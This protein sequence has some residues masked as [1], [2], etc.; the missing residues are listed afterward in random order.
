MKWLVVVVACASACKGEESP[1]ASGD[2]VAE[3]A[4]SHT[5]GLVGPLSSIRVT[6]E[7]V[8]H[9]LPK[10]MCEHEASVAAWCEY[11][12]DRYPGTIWR[13]ERY[14]WSD[15]KDELGWPITTLR[16]TVKGP[17]AD[18]KAKLDSAWGAPTIAGETS[19][20]FAP[21][22]HLRVGLHAARSHG[23]PPDLVDI[24][25]A[26]YL[27]LGEVMGKGGATFGFEGG[28]P[29]L[30]ATDADVRARFGARLGAGQAI[31][32]PIDTAEKP[33]LLHFDEFGDEI[34]DPVTWYSIETRLPKDL[35]ETALETKFGAPTS[36]DRGILV[37]YHRK[38]DVVLEGDKIL[39]GEISEDTDD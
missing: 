14:V 39:V 8:A 16:A 23:D 2:V 18:V 6:P 17:L 31:L 1:R 30:G 5:P 15:V 3:L 29:L 25:F 22:T 33:A 4:A 11:K 7:L 38:P 35:I 9:D 34:P 13:F 19:F 28:R 32:A 26:S 36:D 12:D 10:K 24:D 27:P 37:V 20:W 21:A